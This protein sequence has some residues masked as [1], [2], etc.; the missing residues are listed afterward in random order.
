MAS[1][2]SLN[3]LG[4]YNQEQIAFQKQ[5][6]YDEYLGRVVNHKTCIPGN[7]LLGGRVPAMILSRNYTNI[8]TELFGIGSTN[9]V[10]PKPPVTPHINHLK[11]LDIFDKDKI[12]IPEPLVVSKYQRPFFIE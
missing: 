6:N 12:I 11:T 2:Q 3:T 1:T 8:E 5:R 4:N 9:L 7:G 10:S